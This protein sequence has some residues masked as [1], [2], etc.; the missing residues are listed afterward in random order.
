MAAVAL[1]ASAAGTSANS[2]RGVNP[3]SA[4]PRIGNFQK[5]CARLAAPGR[6]SCHA[7]R[8]TDRSGR[9]TLAAP[10]TGTPVG[11]G[12]P[13]LQSAYKLPSSTNGGGQTVAIVDAFDNPNAESDLGTYRSTTG[14]PAC[15]TANGCFRKVN[16]AGN[17]SPLPTQDSNWGAEI[18]LD[19]DMV[20]AICPNCGIL[21]VEANSNSLNDL[22]SSVNTAASLGAKFI[23]N[24]YGGGESAND[25]TSDTQFYNH[26]G[27]A[28]TASSGDNGFGV[29][30]PAASQFVTSV[31]GTS[32][33]TASNSRGWSETAWS[34]AGS[35]CSAFDPQ[36]SW[37]ASVST[38]CSNRAVSDVSAVADPNT[39]VGVFDTFGFSGW[40]V[41][42]GTSV[43][44]PVI[45]SVY[46]LAGTPGS[47]DYPASYPYSNQSSLF[48]V[49]SGSNGSCSPA[50]LCTAG[51]GWDGPTGLGTPNGTTA[52]TKGGGV[53][54]DFSIS[55][56]PTSRSVTAGSSTTYTVS[57]AITKGSATS[58]TL[59]LG[60]LPSGTSGSF[61]TN[62]INSGGSSTLTVA[63]TTGAS[64]GT[65]T[66]TVKGTSSQTSHTASASLT[67][68][69]GSSTVVTNGGFETGTLSGWTT[70][71]VFSPS[72]ETRNVHSGSFAAQLG[73]MSPVNGDSILQQTIAVPS[74]ATTLSFWYNPNCPDT[75]QFDQEQAQIR[76]T[77]GQILATVLNVCTNTGT[78]THVTF[79]MTRFRG[80]T[81]V[82][83]FNNHDDGFPADPTFTL[84]DDVSVT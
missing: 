72:V 16:Q 64:N 38:G 10:N 22:G 54:N 33:S 26:P 21:L 56:S 36:P 75:L 60:G 74:T 57:T 61:S 2:V 1:L 14:L 68:T 52:F 7:F 53:T 47:T 11:F 78:W 63:T 83:W 45:A 50:V 79:S 39:G 70:G 55:I 17:A 25:P 5:V 35:G 84:L 12:P 82:L 48:D 41:F 18:S 8:R 9:V 24:S 69:G 59:S 42:G 15:T 81:V 29:E 46:A 20:S 19:V 40:Q 49:T 44:A 37:Q 30:Y 71:G 62:P 80:Q 67:I 34:G 28:V 4:G 65:T 43:A 13:D 31:G 58:V 77:S 32:L 76:S 27:V 73:S 6:A 3:T 51:V 23:S 66:F